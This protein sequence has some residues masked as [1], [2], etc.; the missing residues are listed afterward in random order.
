MSE[1]NVDFHVRRE[2][3]PRHTV[4]H[5]FVGTEGLSFAKAGVLV[6]NHDEADE[7]LNRLQPTKTE[8]A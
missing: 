5:V 4:L 8:D 3:G 6:F 2:N 7:F 1:R